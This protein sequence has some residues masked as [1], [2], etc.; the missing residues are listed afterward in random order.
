MSDRSERRRLVSGG[1]GFIASHLV[2]A[3]LCAGA[4]VRALVHQV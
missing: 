1:E 3:L 4:D 2:E